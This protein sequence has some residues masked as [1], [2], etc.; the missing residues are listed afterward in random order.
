MKVVNV[1]EGP[2]FLDD[3]GVLISYTSDYKPIEIPENK[4]RKSKALAYVIASS[5]VVDITDGKKTIS[6]IDTAKDAFKKRLAADIMKVSK[7]E[8][9]QSLLSKADHSAHVGEEVKHVPTMTTRLD[10][11]R[12]AKKEFRESGKVSIVWTGPASDA[13]GYARMN[14][15]FMM[16]LEAQGVDVKYDQLQSLNDM[17]KD[18]AKKLAALCGRRV[19]PDAPKIY[20]MT[21]PLIYDWSR[22]KILFTMMET[23]RLHKD[24][25]ER[26]N[27]ADEIIVPTRWCK[28]TFEESGVKKPISVVPLGVDTSI[29]KPDVEP[30][31]F[32]KPTKDFVFLSVFG[33]S[34]R[35]GYDVLLRA[36]LEEFTADDPVTLVISSRFFGSTDESKKQVIRNDIKHVSS[37]VRN[38]NKPQVVLFGDVLSDPM[39][40]RLFAAADC[41]VLISRGEGFGLPYCFEPGSKVSTKTSIKPIEAIIPGDNVVTHSGS[42]RP[43]KDIVRRQYTGKMISIRSMLNNRLLRCTPE[44]PI[45]IVRRKF[46]HNNDKRHLSLPM[47]WAPAG[48]V[49]KGDLMVV[50]AVPNQNVPIK[51]LDLAYV[52]RSDTIKTDAT[53]VWSKYSNRPNGITAKKLSEASGVSKRQTYRVMEA[54]DRDAKIA[55]ISDTSRLAVVEAMTSTCYDD[56]S[57]IL[58]KRFVD[59]NED[60]GE[61]VGYYAA[62]GSSMKSSVSFSFHSNETHMYS[63]VKELVA[64]IFGI[65]EFY[66]RTSENKYELIFSSAI[67]S[68]FFEAI[69]GKWAIKKKLSEDIMCARES[70]R[71]AFLKSFLLGDGHETKNPV[72]NCHMYNTSSEVLAHQIWTMLMANGIPA[73]FMQKGK[74]AVCRNTEYV[75]QATISLPS[76][77]RERNCY[78][79]TIQGEGFF[80]APVIKADVYD[81]DG[82]VY[83]FEV[84]GD[85]S[86][87]V[88]GYAVHNCEA[89]ACN[90]PVI[91]SRYSGQTDFLDDDNSYLVDVDGF[92]SAEKEL[93]WI[94]YF[95]ENAEF[96]IFG[97]GAIE[98]TRTHMRRVFENREEAAG[99]AQKLYERVTKDYDWST[100]V[101]SMHEKLKQ[102]YRNMGE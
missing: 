51:T 53:H 93:A 94:S 11:D 46:K 84:E 60:F 45:L 40:P 52:L 48:S 8:E 68:S 72:T 14:R 32:S 24:Y 92:R 91:A 80:L 97:K 49:K 55:N 5:M 18:T 41:Y 98:Q 26:C 79:K 19:P 54:E 64:S 95:Y 10:S 76:A 101:S 88:N 75:I 50:P 78:R 58:V 67:L 87:C 63:R 17:D 82:Y 23:R 96:P 30:I 73:T 13:G 27:C 65:T 35:K 7:F 16:G 29:Y 89:G 39:M 56:C 9:Q 12:S 38:T 33:W 3:V 83:N 22:M 90:V 62:E 21:A 25:V 102:T 61:L 71:Q 57:A 20:G 15:K 66:E 34:L 59:V 44:H 1:S 70:V 42:I 69:A 6:D 43:V 37:M 36:Y 4:A 99:K 47:E 86:Y 2:I 77:T 85:N 74:R 28:D 81:Y 31:S 100:C